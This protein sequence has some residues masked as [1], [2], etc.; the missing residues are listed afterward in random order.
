MHPSGGHGAGHG[1]IPEK[2]LMCGVGVYSLLSNLPL[3]MSHR[4]QGFYRGWAGEGAPPPDN[5]VPV[6]SHPGPKPMSLVLDRFNYDWT[7]VSKQ[8]N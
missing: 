5:I 4:D 7:S 3:L 1:P 6:Q 2:F 8:I